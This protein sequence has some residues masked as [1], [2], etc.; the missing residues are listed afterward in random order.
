M[1]LKNG[2]LHL[3][4]TH[5]YFYQVQATMYCTG[6]KW[7]DFVLKTKS[8]IHVERIFFQPDFWQPVLHRLRAFYFAAILP[9]LAV[10]RLQ[11]GG[12]REPTDWLHNP[13][14]WKRRTECF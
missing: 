13:K 14:N 12:I 1:A 6:R 4:H 9:E 10:P 8:D 5:N 7:C 11:Q 3:K 2:S